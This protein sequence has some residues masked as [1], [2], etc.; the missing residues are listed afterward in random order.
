[1]K[2]DSLR[3]VFHVHVYFAHVCMRLEPRASRRTMVK[4]WRKGE[5]HS[6]ECGKSAVMPITTWNLSMSSKTG[7][8]T[9]WRKQRRL[10][11]S[12]RMTWRSTTIGNVPQLQT[13]GAISR[14]CGINMTSV[15]LTC[16]WPVRHMD[17][18][19]IHLSKVQCLFS[20]H[21]LHSL[22]IIYWAICSLPFSLI[23]LH[24]PLPSFISFFYIFSF[25]SHLFKP[26]WVQIDE[27]LTNLGSILCFYGR[28]S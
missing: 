3:L 14:S 4:A 13:L 1:M 18:T 24:P 5:R 16:T 10:W 23:H 17:V 7:W 27:E 19:Y 26:G 12:Q 6:V 2:G 21:F 15:H 25:L 11:P 8:Q 22:L 20:L 28:S 9:P